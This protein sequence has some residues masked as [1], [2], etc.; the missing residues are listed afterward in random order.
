MYAEW[1]VDVLADLRK[2]ARENQLLELAEQLDDTM[3]I[4]AAEIRRAGNRDAWQAQG[5]EGKARDAHQQPGTGD[6][7]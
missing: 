5:Y 7:P 3:I 6:V 4:A 2:F 1:V